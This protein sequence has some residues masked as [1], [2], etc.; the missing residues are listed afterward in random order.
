MHVEPDLRACEHV[1][2]SLRETQR[3]Q[4]ADAKSLPSSRAMAS[5]MS[6]GTQIGLLAL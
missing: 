5:R 2:P 3:L 1:S 4:E 6:V